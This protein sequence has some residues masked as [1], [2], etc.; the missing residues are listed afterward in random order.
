MKVG[1]HTLLIDG[2][3]FIF[4]RLFVIPRAKGEVLLG[5][6]S[7]K[8]QFMRKLAIDLSSEIRKM[9]DYVDDIVVAVDDKSWRKDL[10]PEAKYKGNRKQDSDVNWEALY[11]IYEEFQQIL[12]RKGVT[13]HKIS[14]AEADDVLFAWSTLLNNRGKSCIV[15]TGDKDLIQLV[16]YSAPNDAHTVWFYNSKKKLYVYPGFVKDMETS[17]AD[18]MSSDDILFN[19]GGSHMARDR[20]QSSIM[21]WVKD[22]KVETVEVD[23]DRF[24][25]NKVLIGDKSDNIPS[26]VT[27]GK[28]N[29]SGQ[30]R[31]YSITERMADKIFDQYISE[32]DQD[33]KIDLLFS[34]AE[35]DRLSDVI[36][37]V[38]GKSDIRLIRQALDLNISLMVLHTHVIPDPI[39]GAI[40]K[41][42]EMDWEGAIDDINEML[43]LER[44]LKG[45]RWLKEGNSVPDPVDPFYGLDLP[46]SEP[47]K[48]DQERPKVQKL[49]DLF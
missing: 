29:K 15:W 25:F 47:K 45:T 31:I 2:N 6:D 38:V 48:K 19:M 9:K 42:I 23:C 34:S 20:Y 11:S 21:Q 27:W 17:I 37:R 7:S 3:Y 4:S 44:I 39:L 16:N 13:V 35:K 1:K 49:D 5:S 30:I 32:I 24:I 26:V 41:R 8:S 22:Q 10:Y 18:Q 28:E 40:F 43:S 46:K 36:Y 14:G 33:F 12:S